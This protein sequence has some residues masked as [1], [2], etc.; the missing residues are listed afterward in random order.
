M[1]ELVSIIVPIYNQEEYL[2][3]CLDSIE[4]QTYT[5]LEIILVDDYSNDKSSKIIEERSKFD[6]RIKIIKHK[7]NEGLFQARISG[8]ESALGSYITFVDSDDSISIDWIRT[9]I[10]K[11][12]VDNCDIVAG[13]FCYDYGGGDYK[14]DSLCPFEI[15]EWDLKNGDVLKMFM[16]NECGHFAWHVVWN[17]LYKKTL[18][19]R[20]LKDLKI[21][22]KEHGH[23]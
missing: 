3:K 12:K 5:N 18:F 17:K 14:I 20:K 13:D 4:N 19:D 11:A 8:I 1:E 2:D 6:Q 7:K 15:K 21:Y 16:Q 22:S 9:L 23:R 10:T